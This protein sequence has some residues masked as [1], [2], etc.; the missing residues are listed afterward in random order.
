MI[1]CPFCGRD[2]RRPCCPIALP[3]PANDND[4]GLEPLF[5]A[6][7]DR[8]RCAAAFQALAAK[9]KALSLSRHKTLRRF[10]DTVVDF[11]GIVL[12]PGGM[13]FDRSE[14]TVLATFG[15]DPDCKWV[16]AFMQFAETEPKQR[17]Q[18]RVVPRLRLIDLAFR[19]DDAADRTASS[20]PLPQARAKS[21]LARPAH[22]EPGG[23]DGETGMFDM[24]KHR[25][26]GQSIFMGSMKGFA[27]TCAV[28]VTFFVTGPIHSQTVGWVTA[29]TAWHYG[30]GWEDLVSFVWF[31]LVACMAFFVSRASVSTLIMMGGLAVATRL[32]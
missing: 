6:P 16:G 12:W 9:T 32:F 5:V 2:V 28:G 23:S 26:A 15:D 1:F 31:V 19:I 8:L 29:Y 7:D 3:R 20:H 4:P 30:A 18:W 27:N 11:E 17:P 14:K 24:N 21:D 22:R 10:V 25:E 13:P